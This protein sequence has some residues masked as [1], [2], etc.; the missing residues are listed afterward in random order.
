M[1]SSVG[2]HLDRLTD[3]A[4]DVSTPPALH[5]SPA[6]ASLTPSEWEELR[7]LLP[8]MLRMMLPTSRPDI[9]AG[10]LG[11]TADTTTCQDPWMR[12]PNSPDSRLTV[13]V[14]SDS[15]HLGMGSRHHHH[16]YYYYY[17]YYY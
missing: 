7:T 2:I 6:W 1:M 14:L 13:T 4:H 16:H 11:S 15:K 17:Y 10:V 5:H 3:P 9:S 8:L 12:N